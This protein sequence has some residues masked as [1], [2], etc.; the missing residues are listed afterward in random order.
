M[1]PGHLAACA[2]FA[3]AACG[4]PAEAPKADADQAPLS[5]QQQVRRQTPEMQPVFAYQQLVAYL[6]AHPELE[7]ACA[8]PRR[9]EPRGTVPENVAPDSI[10]AP[11]VGA[12]AYAIQCG[13]QLT[14]VRDDPRQHWLV[15]FAPGASEVQVANCAD[16]RGTDR[17]ALR[18][19]PVAEPAA[20]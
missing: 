12:D 14:T 16:E 20:P 8:G 1:K 10:Y 18:V 3:L 6:Q 9:A 5:L 13:E 11:Y 2:A 7:A 17:C 15:L 4:Q 19:I